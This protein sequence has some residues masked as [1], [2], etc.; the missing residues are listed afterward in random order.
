MG[1]RLGTVA[2]TSTSDVGRQSTI[3]KVGPW[4]EGEASTVNGGEWIE[5]IRTATVAVTV[6][7]DWMEEG[8]AGMP[9]V[10]RVQT[11]SMQ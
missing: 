10:R 7:N 1:S 8:L 5:A 2:H 4:G 6:Q 11:F 9:C 3:G